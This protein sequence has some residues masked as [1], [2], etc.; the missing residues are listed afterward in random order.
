MDKQK[1][2]EEMAKI[3]CTDLRIGC[4]EQNCPYFDKE[5]KVKKCYTNA[6]CETLYENGV[7]K[8]PE[9]AVVLTLKEL[10]A[11]N[12]QHW[13][14]GRNTG[15]NEA[16]KA[17]QNS[18]VIGKIPKNVLIDFENEIR[19]ETAEKFAEMVEFH[20]VAT[21]DEEGV[22]QFTISALALKEILR[23]DF[24]FTNDEICKEITEGK[25]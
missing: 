21:V 14:E 23:E 10:T 1:E 11:N 4:K 22:E 19:K 17:H 7:R 8:I 25:V 18:L 3:I 6:F 2:I 9:G 20:S 16:S 5:R 12:F 13:L 24:G 15:I